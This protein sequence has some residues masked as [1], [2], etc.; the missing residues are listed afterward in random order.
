MSSVEGHWILGG[1]LASGKSQVRKL[2]EAAGITC[3]DADS[4]G[5]EIL[6]P[7]GAAFD[8]VASRW[9]EVVE[10]G[11]IVRRVLGEIVFADPG[12]LAELESITH[13]HI[14]GTIR[15]RVEASSPP[16]V[17]EVPLLSDSLGPGWRRIVVDAGDEDRVQRAVERGMTEEQALARIAAQPSR[18][19]WLA[20]ADIVIPNHGTVEELVEAVEKVVPLL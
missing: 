17:V 1:G 11:V 18:G 8:Q 20:V 14:F 10:D 12:L 19:E 15:A 16:V 5:H 2:L 6:E 3:I 7:G 9:P 13:P 4:V